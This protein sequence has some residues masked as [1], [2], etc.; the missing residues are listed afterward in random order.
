VDIILFAAI[1]VAVAFIVLLLLL[2]RRQNQELRR[3]L[4][5]LSVP[6]TATAPTVR[7]SIQEQQDE[8]P[9]RDGYLDCHLAAVTRETVKFS[10]GRVMNHGEF[11][12]FRAALGVTGQ[13]PPVPI[14]FT[15]SPR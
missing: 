8:Y 6:T 14:R 15:C 11:A 12:L 5:S 3:Q 4:T 7:E 13:P 2:N 9:E 10:V 1:V